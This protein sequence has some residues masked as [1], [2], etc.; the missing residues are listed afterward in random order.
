MIRSVT[1]RLL[2]AAVAVCVSL[3]AVTLRADDKPGEPPKD[4]PHDMAAMMP[5]PA[6]EKLMAL[7]G[8]WKTRQTMKLAG[9]PDDVSEGAVTLAPM[10]GGRFIHE[11][12][13][14]QA[15]GMDAEHFK[16][17]G[18]NNGSKRYESVWTWSLSTGLLH[19]EGASGDEGKTIDWDVWFINEAGMKEEFKCKTTFADADHFSHRL[20]GGK[21]PDG[22][23]GPEMTT[24]YTRVK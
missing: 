4:M 14:G 9:M 13:K 21:M 24:E 16:M 10:L 20:Y 12:G 3:A 11:S 22:S 8:E 2:A 19:M 6:H 5:G 7:A 18:Y 23:P 15:M 1:T 17:W